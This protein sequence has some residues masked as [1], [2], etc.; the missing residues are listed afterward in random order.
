[1]FDRKSRLANTIKI[2]KTNEYE[3]TLTKNKKKIVVKEKRAMGLLLSTST[4]FMFKAR[5]QP[6]PISQYL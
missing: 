4:L 5:R 6:R 2:F 1:M 3:V